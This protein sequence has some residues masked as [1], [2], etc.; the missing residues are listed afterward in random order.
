MI[1]RIFSFAL[2]GIDARPIDVEV[3]IANG[4]PFFA[5]VGLPDAGVKESRERVQSAIQNSGFYFPNTRTEVAPS[6]ADAQALFHHRA[7]YDVDFSDIKGQDLAKRAFEI[8]AAG[9]HNLAMLWPLRP[10]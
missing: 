9:G 8:A 1:A 6:R 5:V 3:D 2:M 7:K 4:R 10:I